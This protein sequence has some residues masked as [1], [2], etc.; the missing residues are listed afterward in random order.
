LNGRCVR[1]AVDPI[2]QAGKAVQNDRFEAEWEDCR[3]REETATR[4]CDRLR[5]QEIR[6]CEIEAEAERSAC[7]AGRAILESLAGH[8]SI[9]SL[10]GQVRASGGLLAIF[11]GFSLEGG[12]DQ[13]RMDLEFSTSLDLD[14][15]IAFRPGESLD[16]LADCIS[17]WQGSYRVK[18]E[19]PLAANGMTGT[20]R[21]ETSSLVTDWSGYVLPAEA[22]PAPLEALFVGD[23]ELLAN[24][25]I[26]L[27]TGK[28]AAAMVGDNGGY[29]A[30]RI[31]FEIKPLPSRILL[32]P[33]RIGYS[34]TLHSLPPEFSATHLRFEV[35]KR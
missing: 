28:V 12:L 33:A 34:E 27:T 21:T 15:T 9:A 19:M 29:Y 6:S 25:H 13:L 1:E 18:I 17:A 4:V 3:N 24:C 16:S 26:G 35:V 8:G 31:N 5:G 32:A 2:C 22:A 10:S 11:S 14:G 30:G 7:Q 20:L 23:P